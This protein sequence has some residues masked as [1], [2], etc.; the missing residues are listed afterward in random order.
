MS[1][2]NQFDPLRLDPDN[3]PS[4][5]PSTTPCTLQP[6][7][8]RL[9][10]ALAQDFINSGYN[11]KSLMREIVNSRAYQLSSRYDGTWDPNSQT[12]FARHWCGG[13]GRRRSPIRSRRARGFATTYNNRRCWGR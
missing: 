2:S 3:P 6:S 7:N 5:C 8:A 10:N 12:L 9:L 4:D 11:L 13:C 1:P